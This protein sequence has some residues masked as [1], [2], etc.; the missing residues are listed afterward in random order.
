MV[1]IKN[2]PNNLLL[3]ASNYQDLAACLG[4][5]ASCIAYACKFKHNL[6]HIHKIRKNDKKFRIVYESV[7]SLLEIQC[8]LRNFLTTMFEEMPDTECAI[9]Y[10]I[11]KKPTDAVCSETGHDY[12][13]TTDLKSYFDHI[14]FEHIEHCLG[15]IGFS[16][17]TAKFLTRFLTVDRSKYTSLQQG[18]PASSVVSNIVGHYLI[19]IPVKEAL[20]L[21]TAEN[22]ISI[23]YLRYCD[24]LAFFVDGDF[25]QELKEKWRNIVC[26]IL[27]RSKFKSHKWA[28]VAKNNPVAKQYFLGIVLNR[29]GSVERHKYDCAR[30]SL[31]N[32]LSKSPAA[33]YEA[34]ATST[35]R[36]E[37]KYKILY[38]HFAGV[39]AYFLSVDKERGTALKKLLEAAKTYW[40]CYHETIMRKAYPPRRLCLTYKNKEESIEDFVKKF[41]NLG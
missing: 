10:R 26:E 39:V 8:L 21:F 14:L 2:A 37:K 20:A 18:S 7:G 38:R 30:A 19:D 9:A 1:N 41:T 28:T 35:I 32:M 5:S 16:Q 34:K 13:M 25:N 29:R 40:G 33:T 17:S 12:L 15:R 23:R 3:N 4:M 27:S 36:S 24:N 31:F 22:G 11:G 6:Q